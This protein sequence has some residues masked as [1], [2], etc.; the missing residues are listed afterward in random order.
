MPK[1]SAYPSQ[2]TA[3]N[4][5]KRLILLCTIISL[6][7]L[8]LAVFRNA[9][10][11]FTAQSRVPTMQ[12]TAR[13]Q[14]DNAVR[15]LFI[16]GSQADAEMA[17]WLAANNFLVETFSINAS[18][19][20]TV[21]LPLVQNGQN[22]QTDTATDPQHTTAAL[23][24]HRNDLPPLDNYDLIIIGA[25][26]GSGDSWLSDQPE[27]ATA[28]AESQLPIAGIGSGGHAF[29]GRLD[30]SIGHPNGI[31]VSTANVTAADYGESQQIYD[32]PTPV[33]LSASRTVALFTAAQTA[34]APEFAQPPLAGIRIATA[35][36]AYPVVTADDDKLLWGF[37]APLSAYTTDGEAL[38]LNALTYQVQTLEIPLPSGPITP[39]P[40]IEQALLD[41]LDATDQTELHALIQLNRLPTPADEQALA[42]AGVE[43]ISYLT[44][45]TYKAAVAKSF[46]ASRAFA[47][48]PLRWAGLVRPDDKIAPAVANS[49]LEA[50]AINGDG[51]LNL[52]VHFYEDVSDGELTALRDQYDADAEL[53]GGYS[54]AMQIA[55]ETVAT[56]AAEDEVVWIEAG[57]EPMQLTL[58]NGR[59]DHYVD[60]VQQ[61]DLS[62]NIIIYRGLTGKDINIG[63]FDSGVTSDTYTHPGLDGR[64]LTTF[65]DNNGHG[66]HVAGIAAGNGADSN[67]LIWRGMAPEAGILPYGSWNAYWMNQALNTHNMDV[68]N[69]SYGH[70]CGGYTAKNAAVD[71]LV[72]GDERYNETAL[73]TH[74]YVGTAGNQGS[75]AQ[76]CRTVTFASGATD[77][78][79]G[80]RGYYAITNNAKNAVIVGALVPGGNL[81]LGSYSSRGPTWDGRIK[82]DITA[83]GSMM[84]TRHI[85]G[86]NDESYVSKGG[87]SMAAPAVAGIV[88]LMLEQYEISF[89]NAERPL[90]ALIKALLLQTAI[91]LTH[92]PTDPGYTAYGW[93]EIDSGEEIVYHPGPDF[94]TGYGAVNADRAVAAVAGNAF[95]TGTVSPDNLVAEF[96]VSVSSSQTEIKF[97]LAWDDEEGDATS[98]TRMNTP[99][100]VNDLDLVL[101]SPDGTYHY[102]WILQ[103]PP[104]HNNYAT[105]NPWRETGAQDPITHATDILPAFPGIDRR[106]NV[107]QVQVTDANGLTAGTWTVQVRVHRLPNNNAQPFAIAGTF[108][109]TLNTTPTLRIWEPTA[110]QTLTQSGTFD[111]I[112]TAE[113]MEDA[114][115]ALTITWYTETENN[116]PFTIGTVDNGLPLTIQGDDLPG[117][118]GV[119]PLTAEVR[120]TDGRT[121]SVQ[122]FININ[123]NDPATVTIEAPSEGETFTSN[124]TVQLR[125]YGF[126]ARCESSFDPTQFEWRLGSSSGSLLG[127]GEQ[128]ETTLPIGEQTIVLVYDD[129]GLEVTD[130]VTITVTDP[131]TRIVEKTALFY[132]DRP[133]SGELT[134]DGQI[135]QDNVMWVGDDTGDNA[136]RAF[137]S[138]DFSTLPISVTNVISA[139]LVFT[140]QSEVGAPYGTLGELS[141]YQAGYGDTLEP[142]DFVPSYRPGR[143]TVANVPNN[144]G[145]QE[146]DVTVAT[147]DAFDNRAAYGDKVQFVF[148]FSNA[149]DSDGANDY[150]VIYNENSFNTLQ[151]SIFITY[152]EEEVLEP[153]EATILSPDDGDVIA[154]YTTQPNANVTL[155]GFGLTADGFMQ[156]SNLRWEYRRAGENESWV[157]AGTGEEIT[158]Q[159]NDWYCN[160][161]TDYE[162]RLIA[163]DG[164]FPAGYAYIR[165]GVNAIIC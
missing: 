30:L 87:T 99:E 49:E 46:T 117:C 10:A 65:N 161:P 135:F 123:L 66:T 76:Y 83:V 2:N 19:N 94:A 57:P 163:D 85:L 51:T 31:T 41:A 72:R 152:E 133:L 77:S 91:D 140:I 11:V 101:I 104:R 53:F 50:W 70:G 136:H 20:Q 108:N 128:L 86:P 43:L 63:I 158:V 132:L 56:L 93:N 8:L 73:P 159:L 39:A 6:L 38:L 116:V 23:T 144:T 32:G 145:I 131:N 89:P 115:E 52:I 154:D 109:G 18:D 111:L 102:P 95:R 34:I 21:Y 139:E 155:D 125:G 75:S 35:D 29:F 33:S 165:I 148:Q 112:A 164:V 98:A 114:D 67:N 90:P 157:I 147:Q 48:T 121:R 62:E 88:A 26:T 113:D 60:E 14:P 47:N 126:D 137:M 44:G 84:S 110:G 122:T 118:G 130:E 28:V 81:A 156:G 79:S 54:F 162:I 151:P 138:F 124:Q 25:D 3:G 107:E 96:P 15:V 105:N 27:I 127:T 16:T 146:I 80:L 134:S 1:S 59:A 149:T 9:S 92:V 37:D 142:A 24:Q 119:V 150:I 103:I 141:A 4:L 78:T 160:Q 97:T 69:H 13:P 5:R 42:S 58:N 61:L 68:S 22:S 36:G 153:A 143:T 129:D 7:F 74:I 106:N 40:G 45:T 120:D 100:L 82:P 71:K 64:L 12:I 55:P 17:N